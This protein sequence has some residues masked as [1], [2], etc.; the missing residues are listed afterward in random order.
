MELDEKD[1]AR[2]TQV[3]KTLAGIGSSAYP[4]SAPVLGVLEKIGATI[5]ENNADDIDFDFRFSLSAWPKGGSTPN[6]ISNWIAPGYFVV[7]AT[8][9]KNDQS[10]AKPNPQRLSDDDWNK[11]R[12]D[13]DSGELVWA[14]G[15][16]GRSGRYTN[17]SYIVVLVESG[18]DS[19]EQDALETLANLQASI[20]AG[21]KSGAARRTELINE[22]ENATTKIKTSI[23]GTDESTNTPPNYTPSK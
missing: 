4:P 9:D 22:L 14:D 12:L 19:T 17:G 10:K 20:D 11:L 1:N 15:V 3:L 7:I 2:N 23:Q 13:I 21:I 16:P 8:E 18:F 6:Y 5:L